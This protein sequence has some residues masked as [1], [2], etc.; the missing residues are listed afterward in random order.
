VAD[1]LCFGFP[2]DTNAVVDG[3][4][5]GMIK[6]VVPVAWQRLAWPLPSGR[7]GSAGGNVT[8]ALPPVEWL[9]K[10]AA[11][12]RQLRSWQVSN[13]RRRGRGRRS[14]TVGIGLLPRSGLAFSCPQSL[15][16]PLRLLQLL[17]PHS[18]C[19]QSELEL[20]RCLVWSHLFAP[21]ALILCLRQVRDF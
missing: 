6:G 16:L 5:L 21:D 3:Q 18:C 12:G 8:N 13:T 11:T 20:P 14:K 19:Y 15:P 4:L 10:L 9:E 17:G 7:Q 1:Y 2:P